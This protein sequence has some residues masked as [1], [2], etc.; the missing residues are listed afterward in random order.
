ML[1]RR[2]GVLLM[3]VLGA[4]C[5]GKST[6]GGGA[7]GSAGSDAGMGGSAGSAGAAGSPGSGGAA[8]SSCHG[9]AAQWTAAT[10]GPISCTKNSD[11][12]VIVNNCVNQAQVVSK[13]A[14]DSGAA[15]LWPYCD[16]QCTACIAPAVEVVCS[17][18]QCGLEQLDP[19]DASADKST[20]RCGVDSM[21]VVSPVKPKLGC[22]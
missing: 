1:S 14:Y 12:C 4:G 16:D 10:Q 6:N 5:S 7:G 18:G 11:C 13:Q 20:S 9:D 3:V 2:F 19:I 17:N 21:P 8:G 22:N 15:D